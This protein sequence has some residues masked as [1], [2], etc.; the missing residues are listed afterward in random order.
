MTFVSKWLGST[1]HQ[2]PLIQL[3]HLILLAFALAAIARRILLAG[4]H[5]HLGMGHT[6]V[7]HSLMV[8]PTDTNRRDRHLSKNGW[9]QTVQQ[10]TNTAELTAF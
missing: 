1:D 8:V 7:W 4:Q 3:L 9:T 6:R 10:Q 5:D 2:Q